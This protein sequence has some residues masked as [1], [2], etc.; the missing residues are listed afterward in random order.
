MALGR[1]RRALKA[2]VRRN[3]ID[4]IGRCEERV[5]TLLCLQRRASG[6]GRRR[7]RRA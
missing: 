4:I 6:L 7:C 1:A 2:D 3:L 5:A